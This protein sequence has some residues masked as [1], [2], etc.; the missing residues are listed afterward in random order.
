MASSSIIRQALPALE[1][2]WLMGNDIRALPRGLGELKASVEKDQ[3]R[4]Y[5]THLLSLM[6]N[7]KG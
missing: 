3:L 1:E 7:W 4:R 6:K 5:L 2:L